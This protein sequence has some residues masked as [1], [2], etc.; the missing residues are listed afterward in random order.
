[1]DSVLPDM[2]SKVL[3]SEVSLP[4]FSESRLTWLKIHF[5]SEACMHCPT[6]RGPHN[7]KRPYIY[8]PSA[9]PKSNFPTHPHQHQ[10][11]WHRHP[12][13]TA[14]SLCKTKPFRKSKPPP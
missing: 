11:T 4:S 1:M 14:E 13:T 5:V 9:T 6:S 12:S 10:Q 7:D 3:R 2:R 8:D